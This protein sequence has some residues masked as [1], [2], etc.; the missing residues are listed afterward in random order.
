VCSAA[1]GGK[2]ISSSTGSGMS[3]WRL[4]GGMTE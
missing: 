1:T 3:H 4:A 2:R